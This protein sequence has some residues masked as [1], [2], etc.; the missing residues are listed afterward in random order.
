MGD[1]ALRLPKLDLPKPRH[2][3]YIALAL[4]VA[5]AALAGANLAAAGGPALGGVSGA[6]TA[7]FVVG[8]LA[9][10]SASLMALGKTAKQGTL[11]GNLFAVAGMLLGVSGV[12]LAAAV[13]ATA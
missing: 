9:V 7:G 6:A 1:G 4:F 13:W 8:Q 10:A 11:W 12:L 2:W 5:T 3:D